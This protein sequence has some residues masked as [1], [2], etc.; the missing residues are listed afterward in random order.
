MPEARS[1][2]VRVIVNPFANHGRGREVIPLIQDGLSDWADADISVTDEPAQAFDLTARLDGYDAVIA[3]GGDGTVYAIVNGLA[4]H[5][6]LQ[7]PLGLIPA[8]SGNDLSKAIGVPRD[9]RQA[10]SRLKTGGQ[11][12]IDL[13]LVNGRYYANSLAI[14]FDARVAH[15]ANEIKDTTRKSGLSLYMTAL[16]RIVLHDYYC[17]DIRFRIDGGVWETKKVVLAAVNNG[18]IYGGGFKI[19]PKADNTDGLLEVCVID[20]MPRWEL[21]LRL[22]FA[23]AG[24]HTWMKKA[25]FYRAKTVEIESERD[26]PA[27]LDGE[28]II[29]KTYRAEIV[30]SALTVI[31]V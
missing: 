23:V 27:A 12:K 31:G 11:K 16:F 13:G 14:G 20:A 6:Q 22:P 2:R 25:H 3:A 26:L 28:L 5:R 1:R 29:D 18:P 9:P 7:I 30:P 17:H 4:A 15:L 10:I 19:T 8:G 21:F 24:R